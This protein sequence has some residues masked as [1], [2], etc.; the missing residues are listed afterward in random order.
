MRIQIA[1]DLHH[2]FSGA[3][4]DAARPVDVRADAD[5][6]VLAGNVNV[7]GG[8]FRLYG[9]S[10]VPVIFVHGNHELH[11]L[12]IRKAQ[13]AFRKSAT[14][15]SV[16]FL[17]R[18]EVSYGGVRFLGCC[19][20]TDY[21]VGP[22]APDIAMREADRFL[23]DHRL[24]ATGEKRFSAAH[25]RKENLRARSWLEE[26]LRMR[27]R[28]RTVVV[29][30]HAPSARSIPANLKGDALAGSIGS[31]MDDLV[32]QADLWIHG[33]VHDRIQ[34]Q[35]GNTRVICNARGYPWNTKSLRRAFDPSFLVEI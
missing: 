5:L 15:T 28:D 23:V 19:L 16:R 20:W 26:R 32:S 8:V 33:H 31:A 13:S 11:G 4:I 18:A 14:G 2:E 3:G 6:L 30:H 21:A 29:T 24:I 35:I 25:A 22:Y 7:G 1:S 27:A 17:E 10:Q 9:K 12:D 34:Y